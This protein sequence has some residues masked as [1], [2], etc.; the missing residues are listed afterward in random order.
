MCDTNQWNQSEI[1]HVTFSVFY[2]IEGEVHFAENPPESDQWFPSYEQLKGSQNNKKQKKFIPFT[3]WI[4]VNA[5]DFRL[6]PLDH[7]T[8]C[9][10]FEVGSLDCEIQPEKGMIF[11][12]L[13]FLTA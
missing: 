5:P 11:Y 9:D 1:E 10:Q 2:L 6:I 4:S 13:L 8:C 12:F 7:N 3:G